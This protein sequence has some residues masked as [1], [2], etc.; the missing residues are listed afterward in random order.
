[1]LGCVWVWAACGVVRCVG[2]GSRCV[3]GMWGS[4][5]PHAVCFRNSLVIG[6]A[7]SRGFANCVSRR[8]VRG[9]WC[10]LLPC[11]PGWRFLV[12][13]AAQCVG[14]CGGVGGG[15]HWMYSVYFVPQQLWWFWMSFWHICGQIPGR[16]TACE[17]CCSGMPF[18]YI[19]DN[20]DGLAE[21]SESWDE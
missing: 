10:I 16:V 5:S 3:W 20:T 7:G 17:A 8:V 21:G 6:W 2:V 19:C 9:G 4:W 14:S 18:T 15:S 12:R 1:M 13:Q 11:I